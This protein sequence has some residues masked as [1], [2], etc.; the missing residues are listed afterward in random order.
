MGLLDKFVQKSVQ[1][2][3]RE[4]FDPDAAAFVHGQLQSHGRVSFTKEDVE[5]SGI[6]KRPRRNLGSPMGLRSA[7][8]DCS[9]VSMVLQRLAA[10][11]SNGNLIIRNRKTHVD[12]TYGYGKIFDLLEKPNSYQTFTDFIYDLDIT[13]H[14]FGLAIVYVPKT[15]GLKNRIT[16][17]HVISP[18]AILVQYEKHTTLLEA[19]E[20]QVKSYR[21][22]IQGIERTAEPDE[23]YLYYDTARNMINDRTVETNYD[24]FTK[25][26]YK[27]RLKPLT[28]EVENIIQAQEAIYSLNK[29]RGAQGILSNDKKDAA[30]YIPLTIDEKKQLQNAYRRKYG[31]NEDDYKIVISDASMRWQSMSYSVRD[32]MLFEGIKSNMSSIADAYNYPFELLSNEKGTTF[33][34]KDAAKAY[35]YQDNIMPAAKKLA[36]F[37][38]QFIP[39]RA[40]DELYFDFSHIEVLQQANKDEAIAQRSI[41]QAMHV[42]YQNRIITQEE[43]RRATGMDDEVFGDT[44]IEPELMMGN[45]F[46]ITNQAPRGTGYDNNDANNYE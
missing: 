30:G 2:F 15:I 36:K 40:S 32:L 14:L 21:V 35:L 4:H 8:D 18:D 7:Y 19:L 16:S 38:E 11:L 1:T 12:E 24:K 23:I 41:A 31:L 33:S 46:S 27:S 3:I 9:V 10:A 44:F 6:G 34:N 20:R 43:F 17:M 29:D 42:M 45:N 37:L 26:A 13:K 5:E 22:K 25:L 28:F 39:I